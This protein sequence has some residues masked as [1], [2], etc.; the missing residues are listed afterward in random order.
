ML[1][2]P[3]AGFEEVVIEHFRAVRPAVL[4]QC[5]QWVAQATS[6]DSKSKMRTV[7]NSQLGFAAVPLTRDVAARSWRSSR[8]SLRS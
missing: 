4:Q 8:P 6:Q 1:R 7:R 5:A 2:R 3:P